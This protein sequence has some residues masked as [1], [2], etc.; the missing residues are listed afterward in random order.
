[1]PCV[2]G[3]EAREHGR[4]CDHDYQ[5]VWTAV[6]PGAQ[7]IARPGSEAGGEP[8]ERCLCGASTPDMWTAGVRHGKHR[9]ARILNKRLR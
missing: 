5:H 9:C 7:Q 3:R 2:C 6:I 4:D 8:F 1:M